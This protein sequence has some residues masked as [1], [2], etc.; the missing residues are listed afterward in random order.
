[1]LNIIKKIRDRYKS[2]E[3]HKVLIAKTM[4]C[5]TFLVAFLFII[6]NEDIS[7]MNEERKAKSII[8]LYIS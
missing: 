8:L 2:K 3:I 5:G 4:I 1:M 6:W 7:R